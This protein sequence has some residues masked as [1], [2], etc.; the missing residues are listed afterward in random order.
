MLFADG[1]SCGFILGKYSI[2]TNLQ[3]L[4]IAILGL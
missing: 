4:K 2:L 1:L 3:Y